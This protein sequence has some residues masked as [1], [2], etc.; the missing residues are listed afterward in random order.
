[1]MYPYYQ[2]YNGK[3]SELTVDD[4]KGAQALYG[5]FEL[6]P[7]TSASYIELNCFS[8]RLRPMT[9]Q[10]YGTLKRKF[11]FVQMINQVIRNSV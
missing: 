9:V 8:L 4:I 10:V 11:L 6:T 2:S 3:E 5:K 7:W 1:M